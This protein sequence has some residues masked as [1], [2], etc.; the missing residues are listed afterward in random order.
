MLL[1]TAL[2][3]IEKEEVEKFN[4]SF[5][6]TPIPF[7]PEESHIDK[8]DKKELVQLVNLTVV[9]SVDKKRTIKKNFPVMK[10]GLVED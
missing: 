10:S 8:C 4:G 7:V 9:R 3:K 1:R 5:F 2:Q 6:Q